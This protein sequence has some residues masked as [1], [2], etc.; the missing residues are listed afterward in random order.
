MTILRRIQRQ[1]DVRL[2]LVEDEPLTVQM[3]AKGLTR[4]SPGQNPARSTSRDHLL[5]RLSFPRA[6]RLVTAFFAVCGGFA[7]SAIP[8][9]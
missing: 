8:D 7:N 3:L 9:E 1:C 6:R 5:R 2:L 4:E